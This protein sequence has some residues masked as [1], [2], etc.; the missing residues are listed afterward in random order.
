VGNGSL[1][2][3]YLVALVAVIAVIVFRRQLR[4]WLEPTGRSRD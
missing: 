3:L 1:E 4:H 2:A